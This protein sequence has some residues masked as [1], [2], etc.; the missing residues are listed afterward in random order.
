MYIRQECFLSFE[1]II[2]FQPET[3]LQMVLAELDFSILNKKLSKP[4]NKRGPKGHEPLPIL[5][6]LVALQLEKIKNIAALVHRL[7]T[8]PIFRYN[9]GFGILEKP[10]SEAT[11]SRFLDKISRSEHLE[12]EFQLLVLKAKEVGIIDASHVAIDSTAISAFE[13]SKPSSKIPKD[14]LSANWG[15]KKDT[16][17][18]DHR[19]F[20]WKLHMLVDCKSELPLNIIITPASVNDG[21]QAIPLMEQLKSHYNSLFCPSYYLMDKIYDVESIYNHIIENTEGQGIIAYNKRTS[22]AP[23][24]GLN[25]ELHPIC[26]MGYELTYWGLDGNYLK[27]RCPHATSKV[28][29]PHGQNWCSNSNYGYCVKVNYKKNHRFFSYPI[30]GSENW[31]SIYNERTSI[32]RCNSRLKEYLNTNNIRSA[33][34]KKAKTWALLNCITLIAGTLAANSAKKI[35]T[36]A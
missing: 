14:G 23:P 21:T 8:D 18:N 28:D 5:Y 19:W 9:C 26:S 27:F 30:R 20:G 16:H 2:K 17:G 7:H 11:F 1:E 6:S 4:E 10:P 24:E 25:E 3:K 22:F 29:C 15:K 35:S 31:Q 13:K 33:G 12:K 34:I 32:E 36:A